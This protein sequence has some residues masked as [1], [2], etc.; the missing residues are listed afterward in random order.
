MVNSSVGA[1]RK[2]AYLIQKRTTKPDAAPMADPPA[3]S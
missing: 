3:A 1:W 2:R